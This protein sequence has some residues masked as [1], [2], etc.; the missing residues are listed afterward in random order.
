MFLY[1][2][3]KIQCFLLKAIRYFCFG[4]SQRVDRV[5]SFFSIRWNWDSPTPSPARRRMCAPPLVPG[6]GAHSLAG[7]GERWSQFRRGY[8]YTVVPACG[9]I[10]YYLPPGSRGSVSRPFRESIYSSSKLLY[11][12]S[13]SS[14][15]VRAHEE[16][17]K[18]M[19]FPS[20]NTKRNKGQLPSLLPA[21]KAPTYRSPNF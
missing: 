1:K 21:L 12:S 5:L 14:G 6:G 4:C 8:P 3:G 17:P 18:I 20:K 11:L 9:C 13:F 7:E 19:R 15:L 10:L 16:T 2:S